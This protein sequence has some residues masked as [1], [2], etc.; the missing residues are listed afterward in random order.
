MRI[1]P[2]RSYYFGLGL[3]VDAN[4]QG[5]NSTPPIV[6]LNF[7]YGVAAYQRWQSRPGIGIIEKYFKDHYKQI[8]VPP[9]RA[10][11]SEKG[12]S[13]DEQDDLEKD[14]TYRQKGRHHTEG[15]KGRHHTS[16]REKA[17]DDLDLVF[18]FLRGTTPEEAAIRREERLKEEEQV[19]QE[20]GRRKVMEWIDTNRTWRLMVPILSIYYIIK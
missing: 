5:T 13:F 8:P 14:P 2:D 16:A 20:A 11:S 1:T 6:L 17:I 4:F 15:R 10:P 7:V 19:A 18:M 3:S 12:S 9:R